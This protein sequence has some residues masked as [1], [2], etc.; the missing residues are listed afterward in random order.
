MFGEVGFVSGRFRLGRVF[1]VYEFV[2]VV[3]M[4]GRV[5]RGRVIVGTC[6]TRFSY[7]RDVFEEFW[8]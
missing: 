8:L 2:E 4:S 1:A 5:R 3:I 7:C 6:S